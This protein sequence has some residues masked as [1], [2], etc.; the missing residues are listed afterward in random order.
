MYGS[1]GNITSSFLIFSYSAGTDDAINGTLPYTKLY[2]VAPSAH[3][4]TALP[5]YDCYMTRLVVE[6]GSMD[7]RRG[8][9]DGE[10]KINTIK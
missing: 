10:M 6:D 9:G 5:L 3:I 4:S 2:N 7:D 8:S 1:S